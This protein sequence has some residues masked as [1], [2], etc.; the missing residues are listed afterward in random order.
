MQL[1]VEAASL[2]DAWKDIVRI[3]K[4]YRKNQLGQHIARGTICRMRVGDRS[5]WVIVH[6]RETADAVAQMDLNV[7]LA[8]GVDLHGSYDFTLEPMSW[9]RSLWFPWMAS[10]PVYRLPAQ[11][12]VVSLIVGFILGVLGILV[13]LH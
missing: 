8:L 1:K 10:D 13:S 12:S 2:E 6:G 11:L 9:I 7:R 3:N 4:A 5:K